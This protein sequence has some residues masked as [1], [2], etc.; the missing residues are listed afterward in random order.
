[1]PSDQA[2]SPHAEILARMAETI[3]EIAA[4]VKKLLKSLSVTG[5]V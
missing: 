5:N 4:D 2:K 3:R 1:M